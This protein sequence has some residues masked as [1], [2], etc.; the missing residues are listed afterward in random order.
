M[1]VIQFSLNSIESWLKYQWKVF[2]IFLIKN[3]FNLSART[4][5]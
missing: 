5:R 1:K 2:D 4:A 3:I